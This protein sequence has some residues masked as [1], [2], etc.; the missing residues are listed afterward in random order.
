[1]TVAAVTAA[2][3]TSLQNGLSAEEAAQVEGAAVQRLA[4]EPRRMDERI[5]QLLM[6][7]TLRAAVPPISKVY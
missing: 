4:E 2:R 3:D 6:D 1:M 7:Y 5:V